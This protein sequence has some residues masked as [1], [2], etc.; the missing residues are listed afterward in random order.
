M[1]VM[2]NLLYRENSITFG[3]PDGKLCRSKE[4]GCCLEDV[5]SIFVLRRILSASCAGVDDQQVYESFE[6]RKFCAHG[7]N[8]FAARVIADESKME[9]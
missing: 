5:V 7:S 1:G 2:E 4:I 9:T 8:H 3:C 6:E